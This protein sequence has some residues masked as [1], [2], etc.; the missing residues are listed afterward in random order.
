M[1][2]AICADS[3]IQTLTHTHTHSQEHQH[4]ELS[5][6]KEE[7]E[8]AANNNKGGRQNKKIKYNLN[9][10]ESTIYVNCWHRFR[11]FAIISFLLRFQLIGIYM[12]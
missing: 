5:P 9:S 3:Q 6:Q 10:L 4:K 2:I 1:R 8:A 7:E 11:V 12:V